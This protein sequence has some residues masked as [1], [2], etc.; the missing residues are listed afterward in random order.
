MI[1]IKK[2]NVLIS[3]HYENAIFKRIWGV[4]KMEVVKV[5]PT[6]ENLI[7]DNY[8]AIDNIIER[9]AKDNGNYNKL[10]VL[11]KVTVYDRLTYEALNHYTIDRVVVN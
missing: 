5:L 2:K 8:M 10:N 11:V 7:K 9:T 4:F 3:K 1:D 6:I